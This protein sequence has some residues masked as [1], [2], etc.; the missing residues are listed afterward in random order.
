MRPV[1]LEHLVQFQEALDGCRFCPMCKPANEVANVVRAESYTTRSRAMIL[2]R[3]LHGISTWTPRIVE[4][5]FQSTLDDIS[6][7][8]CV[9]HYPVSNYVLAARADAYEAGAAPPSVMSALQRVTEERTPD[10][11]ETLLLASEVAESGD[12][13]LAEAASRA[14]AAT[15]TEVDTAVLPSGALAYCLGDRALARQQADRVASAITSTGA[16]TVVVD[17]PQTAWFVSRIFPALGVQMPTDVRVTTLADRLVATLPTDV[18]RRYEGCSALVHDSRSAFLTSDRPPHPRAIQPG[19][20]SDG[21]DLGTGAVYDCP[22]AIVDALGFS[23][24]ANA[25]TRGLSR[26][27][28]A[29]AGL[30]LTYPHLAGSLAR[31]KLDAARSASASHL[32]ASSI[33]DTVHLRNTRRDDDPRVLWLPELVA[34]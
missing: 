10:T 1:E 31:E 9:S 32:V 4:L 15:G 26:S 2:W 16:R 5:L 6:E 34:A 21:D 18:E 24:V 12:P 19:R 30:W 29:D 13:A 22:R 23:R 7:A 33:L 25:W 17:G 20:V 11:C 27:T 8:W 3:I 28:G 14:L